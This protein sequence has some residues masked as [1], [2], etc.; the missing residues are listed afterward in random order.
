MSLKKLKKQLAVSAMAMTIVLGMGVSGLWTASSSVMAAEASKGSIML[1]TAQYILAPGGQYTIG[2]FIKDQTG[3]QLTASGVKELVSQGKLRVRDSRTGSIVDLEQLSAGH[4]RVTGKS[5]GTCWILYEIGGTHASVRIDVQN[6]VNQ[7][8]TA[9]R[10]TSFFTQDIFSNST[11]NPP[12]QNPSNKPEQST[13][14][15]TPSAPNIQESKVLVAYFSATNTTEGVAQLLADGMN[16]DIYE[17]LP[18]VPYTSADLNYNNSQSRTS[19]E[20]NNPNAR[21]AI[22]G[23]VENMG[24]YDVIFLGYPI[25]HGQA[26]RIMSTFLESYH[27]AGKTII[28]FCTSGSSGI[29]LSASNLAQLTKGAQWLS[30]RRLN[31]AL[32]REL[33]NWVDSLDLDLDK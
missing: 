30:G 25:W 11:P 12:A 7:H 20:R 10:N 33:M 31:G 6:G 29:G 23:S 22:A 28:P 13:P 1:D 27:F 18:A 3:K 14:E 5:P 16:A 21:P 4:F 9:V 15:Q 26:P 32:Q 24:Q 8:G 2:A 17:I 19:L